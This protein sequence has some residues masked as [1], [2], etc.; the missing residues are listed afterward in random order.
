MISYTVGD[1][2]EEFECAGLLTVS[3]SYCNDYTW[4]S[5][6]YPALSVAGSVVFDTT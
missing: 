5:S 6:I 4:T 2:A 1:P 3:P